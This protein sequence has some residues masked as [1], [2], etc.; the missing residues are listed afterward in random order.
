[1]S[2]RNDGRAKDLLRTELLVLHR[3]R[4]LNHPH[5]LAFK[6]AFEDK[7]KVTL[8]TEFLRGKWSIH[9]LF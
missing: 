2:H 8:V 3:L 5:I 6:H 9:R 7:A 4:N 1:M